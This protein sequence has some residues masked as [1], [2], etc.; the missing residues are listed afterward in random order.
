MPTLTDTST[1]PALL[2]DAEQARRQA[3]IDKLNGGGAV[4]FV[5]VIVESARYAGDKLLFTDRNRTWTGHEVAD[6]VTGAVRFLHSEGM[7]HGDVVLLGARPGIEAMI[8]LLASMRLGAICTVI[9]PGAGHELFARRLEL[10][11]P[12]WVIAESLLYAASARTPLKA[13]TR[14]KGMELPHLARIPSN[15]VRIGP[16]VPGTPTSALS[17][18]TGIKNAIKNHPDP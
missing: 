8:S 16:W 15:H 2:T 9:D 13:Y 18:R 6:A 14:S 12:G 5:D 1:H 3:A 17:L 7:R 11:R 4:E 10:M